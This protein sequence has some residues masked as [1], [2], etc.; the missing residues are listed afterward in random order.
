MQRLIVFPGWKDAGDKLSFTVGQSVRASVEKKK[1]KKCSAKGRPLFD[2]CDA[3]HT[4]DA[5]RR[6]VC[7]KAGSGG[8]DVLD[9]P[10]L[11]PTV[12]PS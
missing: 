2:L 12:C 5:E 6:E 4:R 11:L 3:S 9:L 8:L 10:V 1:K 7:K